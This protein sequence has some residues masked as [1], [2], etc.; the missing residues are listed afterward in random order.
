MSS[1][2][3]VIQ[4]PRRQT[5]V[6]T[7]L[8]AIALAVAPVMAADEPLKVTAPLPTV[9]E[10][11]TLL[12][13]F[14]RVAYTNEGYAT[15]GYRLA[16][17]QVGKEWMML[18]VGV[19]LRK[20]TAEQKLERTDFTVTT[21]DGAVVPLATQKEYMEGS[22]ETRPLTRRAQMMRDSVNYLPVDADMPCALS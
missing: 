12:G 6:V 16:Q 15:M 9:A 18:L 10:V 3:R 5:A 20:P 22:A 2:S 8:L 4:L 11:F 7:I 19:T 14:V 21:P 13:E 1:G 17:D